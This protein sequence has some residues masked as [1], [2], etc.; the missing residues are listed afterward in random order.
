MLSSMVAHADIGDLLADT[1]SADEVET[2][3]PAAEIYRHAAARTGTSIDE[4]VHVTSGW[5]DVRG[6]NTPTCRS[7]ES[8]GR[9]GRGRRSPEP[10]T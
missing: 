9:D 8:T 4:I 7:R 2:F 5:Y 3:E 1:I 6:P 10:R